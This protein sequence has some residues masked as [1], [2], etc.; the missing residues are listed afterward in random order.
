KELVAWISSEMGDVKQADIQNL[1]ET[2]SSLYLV[3]LRSSVKPE[4]LATDVAQS[5]REMD[6]A[7]SADILKD[8]LT[9]LLALDS[10]NL[11]DA[12]AK[13]LQ[14]EAEHAFCD[15]RILTD[16]RPVFGSNVSD[17]P[18]AMII[19]HT[20]KIGYHDSRSQKHREMYIALD[21][22]D[23]NNL[24]EVLKR[25]QDKGKSLKK[26]LAPGVRLIEY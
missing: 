22:D 4:Q 13:E 23:I 5:F 7:V 11:V 6:N 18:E 9:T 20:L 10:L 12:K 14:I 3:R 16:L 8:R 15:S 1:V 25:A 19:V 21:A 17:S 2:L 26:T 24:A